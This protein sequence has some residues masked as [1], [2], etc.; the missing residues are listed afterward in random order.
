VKGLLQQF[1]S[2]AGDLLEQVDTGLLEL[3]RDPHDLALLD[4]VFRAAHTLK[5]SSGLFDLPQLTRL[6][7]AAEDLLDAIRADRLELTAEMADDL[8]AAF[9]LIR[10]WLEVV[11]ETEA[12][13]PDATNDGAALS[14][15]L[16]APLGGEPAAARVPLPRAGVEQADGPEG[17]A[18]APGWLLEAFGAG[19]IERTRGWL[20]R[21]VTRC[22]VLRF[23][24]SEQCFFAGEDPLHLVAQIPAIE[25]GASGGRRALLALR[26]GLRCVAAARWDSGRVGGDEFAGALV[27]VGQGAG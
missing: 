1:L 22:R 17:A 21:A 23:E 9:D 20:D 13:P 2:E 19:Q 7:H 18:P 5:G 27:G 6:T 8:L 24:P 16:R 15:R 14:A 11:E 25:G 3:E 4:V 12:L 10:R 26:S